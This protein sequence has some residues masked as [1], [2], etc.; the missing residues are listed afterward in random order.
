MDNSEKNT[1]PMTVD[2]TNCDRE[3]I[4]L[5]GNIQP[6]GC[7]IAL[8]SDWMVAYCSENVNHYLGQDAQDVIGSALKNWF[9]STTMHSI[10]T[11]LQSAIITGRNER[12]FDQ[13]IAETGLD[14]DISV[15]HNGQF[16]IVEC[17]AFNDQ[18]T[19]D[20]QFVRSL[21]TQFYCANDSQALIEMV[22]QQL[23][24]IT[25]YDRVMVYRFL[26][27]GAGEVIAESKQYDVSSYL[28]LRYP[29]SDIPKQARKLYVKNLLRVI[30]DV[31][32]TVVPIL[33]PNRH[34]E[35]QVDL[36]FSTLRAVSPIHIEYLKNMGVNASMS[37]S[38]IVNGK[39]WG[40]FACHHYSAKVPSYF[41]RTE[42]EL[43]AEVFALEL[44]SRLMQEREIESTRARQLHNNMISTMSSSGGLLDSIVEQFGVFNDLI[45]SDGIAVIVDGKAKSRGLGL[46]KDML[47]QLCRR[48]N[49]L[50]ASE[51]SYI[52]SLAEFMPGYETD[53][54]QV[55]GVLAIPISKTPRDYLLFFRQ[56]ETQT[57]N[58]AGNPQKAVTLGPNGGRLTPRSSFAVWQQTHSDSCR[59]WSE[60]EQHD[61]ESLRVTLLEV[62]IRF[63]Q[64]R[65]SIRLQAARKHEILISELNH[66]VRN[67]L[68]LVNAVVA[69]T[70]KQGRTLSE[71]IGVLT[72]RLFALASAHD[73]LTASQWSDVSFKS[74]LETEIQAYVNTF[75]KIEL[76]GDEVRLSPYAATP[77]V[78]VFHEM[79]TNAAKYGALSD[80][81]GHGLVRLTWSVSQRGELLITW[82]ETGG[83]PV[84]PPQRESFGMTLIRTVMPHELDGDVDIQFAP[85]GIKGT[86]RLPRRHLSF[87]DLAKSEQNETLSAPLK[88]HQLP[89]NAL[90]VED[91]LIIALDL[92]KRLTR[93]GIAHVDIAG[94]IEQAKSKISQCLPSL[95]LFDVH[96]GNET[97]LALIKEL[98][99][100]KVPVVIISGYGEDLVLPSELQDVPLLTK[101]VGD[102]SLTATLAS[103]LMKQTGL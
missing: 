69:Q 99:M 17:E 77:L 84:V 53:L 38:I 47:K 73:Q 23:Q 26:P 51:V 67:I 62:M 45:N 94:S 76:I 21:L 14:I 63:A 79:F 19:P 46:E 70:E 8:R 60:Q 98:K 95:A 12:I 56:G 39:L 20:V 101:P 81:L 43:F 7:F 93:M 52:H 48:L 58:W 5:L 72:G 54:H 80:N 91:S 18:R 90:V 24:L 3:P 97:T 22:T 68:N 57:V 34:A 27:D 40:L 36:S 11:A 42:L 59:H 50:S 66:R 85:D 25:G 16:I 82:E 4:H 31:D 30:G 61:A 65:E 71:F 88:S 103:I 28:G 64:E 13:K 74:L 37:I 9:D 41:Q 100:K 1:A 78:L 2:L 87:D 55:A 92:Q 10:R 6:F 96:L 102:T 75:N 32:A 33:P 83:P 29:A 86:F 89:D 49:T 44:S 15:H 35:E